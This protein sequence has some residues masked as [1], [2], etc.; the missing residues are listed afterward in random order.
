MG[1]G[2]REEMLELLRSWQRS[3]QSLRSIAL[4]HGVPYSQALYWR[5]RLAEELSVV[6]AEE[7]ELIEVSAPLE[8]R[9]C[10]AF[11]VELAGGRVIRIPPAFDDEELR[12]L[13]GALE[14]C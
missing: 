6:A 13:V 8:A 10:G 9:H 14:G 2:K 7:V 3:G 5:R 11:E 1:R 4:D 12:R